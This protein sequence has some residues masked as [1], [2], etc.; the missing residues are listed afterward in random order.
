[1]EIETQV[2]NSIKE[3]S[4]FISAKRIAQKLN[5]KKSKINA[6]LYEMLRKKNIKITLLSPYNRYR[7]RPVWTYCP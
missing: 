1:M 6:I 4:S 3:C 2:L 7:K 5:I